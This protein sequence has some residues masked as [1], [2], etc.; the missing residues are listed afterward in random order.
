MLPFAI[1]LVSYSARQGL[2]HVEPLLPIAYIDTI[3]YVTGIG[4]AMH[5]LTHS[6]LRYCNTF[7]MGSWPKNGELLTLQLEFLPLD[8]AVTVSMCFKAYLML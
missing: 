8:S 6:V 1:A 2:Q 7:S 4:N 3:D 5:A